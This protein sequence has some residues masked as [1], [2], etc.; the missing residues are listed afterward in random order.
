MSKSQFEHFQNAP[1]TEAVID[2]RIGT[3][4]DDGLLE[5]LD[6]LAADLSSDYPQRQ[7]QRIFEGQFHFDE[8]EWHVATTGTAVGFM[9]RSEDGTRFLQITTAGMTA[10]H[11]RPYKTWESLHE[12]AWSA[13]ERY[14]TAAE[15][16]SVTRIATRFINHIELPAT[17]ATEDYFTIPI[18][19]PEGLPD[20]L[21]SYNYFVVLADDDVRANLRLASVQQQT[22]PNKSTT[23]L[24]IDCYQPTTRD[25]SDPSIPTDLMKLRTLKNRI[26]FG[27]LTETAKDLFR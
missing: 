27:S 22:D 12:E 19:V 2:F 5:R 25:P 13:W 1:I 3:K 24:D 23:L 20:H 9:I 6:A 21:M 10:G 7:V 4:A 26:F 17:Y 11:L 8:E 15:P 18:A 14:I 16:Q